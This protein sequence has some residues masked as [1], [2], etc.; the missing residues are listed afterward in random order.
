[1]LMID[2]TRVDL[3]AFN[4]IPHLIAPVIVDS[5]EVNPALCALWTEVLRRY[6]Q[7]QEAGCRTITFYSAKSETPMPH[8]LI[9][10]N[11]LADLMMASPDIERNLVRLAQLGRA[12]G[13]HLVLATRRPSVNVVTGLL[14]ENIPARVAFAVATQV[15]SRVILDTVGAEKLLG[16]GDML[17]LNNDFPKPRRVQ[18]ALVSDEEIDRVVEFWLSRKVYSWRRFLS[19][20]PKI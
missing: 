18:G 2:P 11:E 3:T 20:N 4:G 13:I 5:V 9:I 6:K 17:L 1:M 14:K 8:I 19:R 16:K 15:D 10:V 12:V 7:L